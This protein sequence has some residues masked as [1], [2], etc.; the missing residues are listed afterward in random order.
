MSLVLAARM[1]LPASVGPSQL[2]ELTGS[3]DLRPFALTDPAL[4]RAAVSGDLSAWQVFSVAVADEE[5]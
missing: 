2:V 1:A 3:A 4:T 5:Q